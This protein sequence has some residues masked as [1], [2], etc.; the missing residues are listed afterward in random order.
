[1][2]THIFARNYRGFRELNFVLDGVTFLVGDNSSGK[3]S[4]IKLVNYIVGTELN[5]SPSLPDGGTSGR[6]DFFSPYFDYADV[7]LGFI[8]KRPK[9]VVAKIMTL[10]QRKDLLTP[11]IL[12]FTI[13]VGNKRVTLKTFGS[14][15][16]V[17]TSVVD[18]S[19]DF[20]VLTSLHEENV[21]FSEV[22]FPAVDRKMTVLNE[23]ST[24][25]E[26]ITAKALDSA[27]AEALLNSIS[28]AIPNETAHI[29]PLRGLP[30]PYY[31]L[32]RVHN[33][34]GSHF[35]VMWHDIKKFRQSE[36]IDLVRQFGAESQL[37]EEMDVQKLSDKIAH[38]PLVV[39]IGKRGKNFAL[40]QVGVGVSQVVPVLVE[41]VFRKVTGGGTVMLLQQPELHL[42]PIAQAALGEFIYKMADSKMW[43]LIE[44]H[45]DYL[46]DRFRS[47]L[48]GDVKDIPCKILFCENTSDGNS[49]HQIDIDADG[50]LSD[51]PEHYR[52]F[53]VNEL[54]RTMF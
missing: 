54:M 46:M 16:Q 28:Q 12:R 7:D 48:R 50:Y 8:S 32:E 22:K 11:M 23:P 6:Y 44:T 42:H 52:D 39:T 1:M 38:S 43:Y 10:R 34:Q 30:E 27:F 24:L 37:F 36:Y 53:Q 5:S 4:V 47:N 51:P 45:S 20:D 9:R 2:T 29:G 13:V 26:V 49:A 31:A 25:Y 18:E 3:S 21:G 33:S 40:S 14:K 41:S 19:M 35:A 15:V 17:K